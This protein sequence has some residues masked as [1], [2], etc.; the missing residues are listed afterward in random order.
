VTKTAT[1]IHAVSGR[2][3]TRIR[4]LAS[5]SEPFVTTEDLAT[6]WAVS[7]RQIYKQIE[8]GKLPAIRLG[9]RSLRIPTPA[10]AEFERR[11]AFAPRDTDGSFPAKPVDAARNISQAG[12][13]SRIRRDR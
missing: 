1:Y 8:D 13:R 6:Y 11:S 12:D 3:T 4:D 2:G 5:H 10:A 7:R 9:P